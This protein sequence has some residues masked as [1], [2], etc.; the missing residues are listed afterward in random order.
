[1]KL[2]KEILLHLLVF[3]ILGLIYFAVIV[4]YYGCGILSIIYLAIIYVVVE[5][6]YYFV[7]KKTKFL[8]KKK[9][10]IILIIF[11]VIASILLLG[12][13]LGTTDYIIAKNGKAPI[14]T[15]NSIGFE[16]NEFFIE[17]DESSYSGYRYNATE[18]YGL[19][20]KIVVCDSCDKSVYFMPFGIGTYAWFIGMPVDKLDGRWFHA[21]SN[22]IYLSFDGVG[23]YSLLTNDKITEEGTYTLDNDSL[24]L[25]L[26]NEYGIGNCTIENNYQELHCDNYD[27]VFMK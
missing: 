18:Y 22:D 4:D 21:H 20:Y 25:T 10:K 9:N 8:T 23:H 6:V 26:T 3:I 15:F 2:F 5:L 12:T 16:K 19:G 24:T 7:N 1:M 13:I 17:N 14:F 27:D 11:T